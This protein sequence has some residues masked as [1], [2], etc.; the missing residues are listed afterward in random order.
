MNIVEPSSIF[1]LVH[2]FL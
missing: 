1:H 2:F